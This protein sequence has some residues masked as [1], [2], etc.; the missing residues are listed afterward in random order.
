MD[1]LDRLQQLSA[2]SLD[3]RTVGVLGAA[4]IATFALPEEVPAAKRRKKR[5]RG[6]ST[7]ASRRGKHGGANPGD[8]QTHEDEDQANATQHETAAGR[9]CGGLAGKPCPKGYTCVDDP[10]DDCDPEHGGADCGGICVSDD[11]CAARRCPA[12]TTCC[13]NC[14]GVCVAEGTKCSDKLC[15]QE[16]C[17]SV[18]CGPGEECCNASCST[19]VPHG[20]ACSQQ[21]CVDPPEPGPEPGPNPGPGV[22]CGPRT[23]RND[24]ICCDAECGICGGRNGACPMI[25]CVPSGP[26]PQRCGRNICGDGEYCCNPS[27]GVCAPLDGACTQQVCLDPEE[28]VDR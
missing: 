18:V 13:P 19:C 4:I 9:F 7:S 20:Y 28:A 27:C 24:Q 3:R 8:S 21:A 25:A 1:I 14:G 11:P 2:R 16:T 22:P 17:G 26:E 10:G 12:E 23:C 5:K 15:R 6:K